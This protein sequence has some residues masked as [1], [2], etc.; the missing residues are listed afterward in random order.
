MKDIKV[1]GPGCMKCVQL[2]ENA[3]KAAEELNVEY[4]IEKVTD[5]QKIME[6]GIMMT[7]ALLVNGE[8]KSCGKVLSPEEIKKLISE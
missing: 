1:L 3:K 2:Y 4:K 8:V 5:I 6:Y 7:P